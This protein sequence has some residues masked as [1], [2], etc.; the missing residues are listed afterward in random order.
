MASPDPLNITL[1]LEQLKSLADGWFDGDG[2][3]FQPERLD[4]LAGLLEPRFAGHLPLPRLYPTIEGNVLA[5]WRIGN[6]DLSLEIDLFRESA[7]WH[8]YDLL[9]RESEDR[10]LD[11]T[12]V[13]DLDWLVTQFSDGKHWSH[14][15]PPW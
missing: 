1:Q 7:Y 9:T 8:D 5:E 12:R 14:H 13:E 2:V 6:R 3:R 4:W 11:L 10:D 15:A